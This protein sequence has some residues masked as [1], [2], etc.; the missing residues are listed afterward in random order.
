MLQLRVKHK[1]GQSVITALTEEDKVAD[2][3]AQ[4]ST[5]THI[6]EYRIK[7]LKG[8][9]PL[10]VD[11]SNVQMLLRD[12]GLQHRDT[13]LVEE[14]PIPAPVASDAR[15]K[16]VEV[17]PEESLPVGQL[18]RTGILLRKVVPADNSCL[19][20]SIGYC[21]SGNFFGKRG[22]IITIN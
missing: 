13:L 21:L 16:T 10:P 7:I 4:L 12:S 17:K 9:P 6:P 1:G 22:E 3:L 5:Q 19:F 2:L 20:T 11:V 18:E 8:F 14:L 15:V